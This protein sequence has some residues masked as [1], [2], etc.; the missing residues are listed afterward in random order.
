VRRALKWGLLVSV[1]LTACSHGPF[2]D[3]AITA[4]EMAEA[5][6]MDW[7]RA[8]AEMKFLQVKFDFSNQTEEP[9]TLQAIDFS[10]RDT[11]GTLHPYSAQVLDM[12]QP[13]HVASVRVEPEQILQGS[14]IFQIPRS[15]RPA[16]LIYLQNKQGGLAVPL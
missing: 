12:G 11:A 3:I 4:V 14:V 10:L 5:P 8:R 15:A 1:C 9:I 16:Q 13:K 7:M 6:K 2:D